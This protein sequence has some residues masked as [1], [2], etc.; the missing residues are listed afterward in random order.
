MV[1]MRKIFISFLILL[2]LSF[3]LAFTGDTGELKG[4][5]GNIVI[6]RLGPNIIFHM[7]VVKPDPNIDAR[8]LVAEPDPNIDAKILVAEPDYTID[9]EI[10]VIDPTRIKSFPQLNVYVPSHK[11]GKREK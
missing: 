9:R 5:K 4:E 8:I 11:L 3:F 10:L 2:C 7:K 1:K 6:I